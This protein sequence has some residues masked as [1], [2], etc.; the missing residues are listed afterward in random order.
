[1]AIVEHRVSPSRSPANSGSVRGRTGFLLVLGG[2]ILLGLAF[3]FPV[4]GRLWNHVFNLL[5]APVVCLLLL[6]VAGFIDPRSIGLSEK[7]VRLRAVRFPE[8]MVIASGCFLLGC[9]GELLQAFTGRTPGA[10]DLVANGFGVISGVLWMRSRSATGKKRTL[11]VITV[12]IVLSALEARALY[13]PETL[14]RTPEAVVATELTRMALAYL[15]LPFDPT[16]DATAHDSPGER[17]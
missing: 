1:M 13:S 15:G 10:G 14:R 17:A 7:F 8:T 2:C 9:L 16:P 12:L 11:L 3:P 6:T 4:D 5:H